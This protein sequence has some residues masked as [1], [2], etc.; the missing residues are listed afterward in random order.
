MDKLELNDFIRNH[1]V[2]FP[3]YS[4]RVLRTDGPTLITSRVKPRKNEIAAGAFTYAF[5]CSGCG[6]KF[7]KASRHSYYRSVS[8]S[9]PNC[10]AVQKILKG[11]YVN[12]PIVYIEKLSAP[13]SLSIKPLD[14]EIL[15]LHDLSCRIEYGNKVVVRE[16]AIRS[17]CCLLKGIGAY[18]VE[19]YIDGCKEAPIPQDKLVAR[20]VL[21]SEVNVFPIPHFSDD[22]CRELF[23][24]Y[25]IE[26]SPGRYSFSEDIQHFVLKYVRYEEKVREIF[27]KFTDYNFSAPVDKES[28][29]RRIAHREDVSALTVDTNSNN[30]L[31]IREFS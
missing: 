20:E 3:D 15:A 30:R 14:N 17:S 23:K 31:I 2:N 9:C 29:L 13:E 5:N 28:I 4:E 1:V 12:L 27:E 19:R 18:K 21:P 6:T 10:G 8:A 22:S 11:E 24:N 16:P 7:R 25:L 26:S